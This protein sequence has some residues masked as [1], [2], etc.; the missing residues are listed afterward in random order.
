MHGYFFYGHASFLPQLKD[1]HAW[2]IN[3]S[4]IFRCKCGRVVVVCLSVLAM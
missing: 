4:E 2:K 1:M 3:V